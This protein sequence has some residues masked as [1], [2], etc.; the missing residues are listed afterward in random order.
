MDL[1]VQAVVALLEDVVYP[2]GHYG[3]QACR[4]G[5]KIL[6]EIL[7]IDVLDA[8]IAYYV[9][10]AEDLAVRAAL[11]E[12]FQEID[13]RLIAKTAGAMA[14]HAARLAPYADAE[15]VFT[16]LHGMGLP[17]GLIADGPSCSQ[18]QLVKHLKLDR[19]FRRVVYSGEL[20]GEQPW[21][22]ALSMM[23][24]LLDC[25]LCC[26]ALVCARGGQA[27]LATEKVG[28]VYRVFRNAPAN[29][30]QSSR[31]SLSNVIPM[32]NLYDL[33]EALGLVAWPD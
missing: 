21:L 19:I 28:Q 24:L 31:L 7:D 11:E 25:P 16:M 33:P 12:R 29:P 8:L 20:R 30:R 27:R 2:K 3:E 5:A 9:P 13:P 26:I 6:E 18:R 4:A 17:L 22:D 10:G 32:L 15:E 14:A 23:E 1:P